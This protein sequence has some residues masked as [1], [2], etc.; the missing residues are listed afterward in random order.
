MKYS[1]NKQ[2]KTITWIYK[3]NQNWDFGFIDVEWKEKWY[4]VFTFNK[5]DALDWDE[6][7]AK[8][9]VFK[10][11]EEAVV[12]KVLKRSENSLVWEFELAKNKN[13][14]FVKIS[15]KSIKKDIF[16]PWKYIWKSKTWDIVAVRITK[17]TGKNPEWKILEIIWKNSDKD[18]K[19][20]WFIIEAWFKENFS[21]EVIKE[22]EK[23]EKNNVSVIPA[24]AGIYKKEKDNL[25]KSTIKNENNKA[26]YQKNNINKKEYKKRKDLRNL[27][28]FTIDSKDAKDLD[29]AISVK[30]KENGDYRL[31][32][33][34]AD[35]THYVKEKSL[36]DKEAFKRWTSVY[37]P[38]KVLPMLPKVLSNWLC[39]LN[40]W[41]DKLTLTSEVILWK[42][43]EIKK[44]II[45]ESIIKSDFRLTYKEVDEILDSK[46]QIGEVLIF[47]KKLDKNLIKTLKTANTLKEILY[48]NKYSKWVLN[49]DFPELKLEIDKDFNTKSIWIY[50]KYA[51]N[52]LIEEF[53]VLANEAVSRKMFS[54]PFLY[55]IHER[56]KKEDIERLQDI[57]NLYNIKFKFTTFTT[58]EFSELLDIISKKQ[59]FSGK[60]FLENTILRTLSKA[61]YSDKNLWHFWLWLKFY[62]HF[63]SPIRR[64]PDL[65]IHRIIKDLG[66]PWGWKLSW[67]L[68]KTRIIHYKNILKQVADKSSQQERKAEKLE[69]KVKDYFIC[70]YYENKIWKKFKWV[71][72]NIIP[73]WF[74]MQ[75]DNLVEGFIEKRDIFDL[76]SDLWTIKDKKIGNTYKIWNKI[77]IILSDID[78]DR[79]K[80][81]FKIV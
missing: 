51:S 29:D 72:T 80:L 1:K 22:V 31:F 52:K 27:F 18:I 6:V 69:Y 37:L 53:M 19:I 2:E 25:I 36:L 49:F 21:R 63:T 79:L 54:Y 68:N 41:E 43:W 60:L 46:K 45:Y 59:D 61:I 64:Y 56:P 28:T 35:V 12:L 73:I 71:I 4:Y 44:T 9:K 8:V 75:L 67:K 24:K 5:K 62:S 57:L 40:Q 76:D 78:K 17:W 58:K 3:E 11:R 66:T 65:Q 50:P 34:I 42:D 20:K 14:G 33:H 13:F 47:K 16:I 77:S 81:I 70:K 32:V 39:S 38:H 15:N 30:Q 26:V 23:F 48:K 55:R 10:G 74:F 7:L